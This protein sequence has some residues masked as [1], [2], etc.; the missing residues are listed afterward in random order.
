[1]LGPIPSWARHKWYVDELYHFLFV[2]P[3]Y[4][5]AHICAIIDKIL[6]DGLVDLFGWTPRGVGSSI[7]PAQSGVLHDYALR[8][9]SGIGLILL[10]VLLVIGGRA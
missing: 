3:L 9:V 8:M 1:M 6:V 5:I 4:V 7:R 10:I 2:R